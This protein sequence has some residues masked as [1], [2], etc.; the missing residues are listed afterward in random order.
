M[1]TK[2]QKPIANMRIVSLENMLAMSIAINDTPFW[3]VYD[4][5]KTTQGEWTILEGEEW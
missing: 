2:Y 5:K 1:K 4:S 3:G